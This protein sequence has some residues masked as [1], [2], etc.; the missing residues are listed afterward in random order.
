MIMEQEA[1]EETADLCMR[2]E[3]FIRNKLH[4]I[5]GVGSIDSS[6]VYGVVKKT[7]VFPMF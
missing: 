1:G 5:G 4:S 2:Y 6:F 3:D 7:S